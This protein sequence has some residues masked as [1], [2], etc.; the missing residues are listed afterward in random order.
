M[1]FNTAYT[2]IKAIFLK[3]PIWLLLGTQDIKLRYRRSVIGPF[4][5]TISMAVTIY[6]MGFLY[7]H[8][9]KV[10]LNYYFPYLAT[11][12]IG[13]SLISTLMIEGSNVYLESENYIKNQDS[14][15][16]LFMMRLILKNGIIFLHNLIAFI[17]II[18]IFH[19]GVGFKTLLIIPGLLIIG[20]NTICWGTLAAIIGTRY[21]D[22]TPIIV[23]LVQIIFFL[24]PI[25]WFPNLLPTQ[26]QWIINYNPCNQFLNL[27]RAP[28][29]NQVISVNTI[30]VVSIVSFIGLLLYVHFINQYKH[31]I[32][33]WL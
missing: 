1:K 18:F 9:F 29:M 32:V 19:I 6:S 10:D 8:L 33:F 25:V 21:R 3:W 14:F 16:S 28:L 5:I 22:F 17:P 4:W 27:I 13:W 2:E 24:T 23:S 30:C 7:G 12:I 26:Y 15:L 20:I 31:R 11:G